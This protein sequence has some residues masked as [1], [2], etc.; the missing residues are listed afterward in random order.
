MQYIGDNEIVGKYLGSTE[1]EKQYLGDTLVWEKPAA[2]P[3]NNEIWYTSSDGQIVVPY[4]GLTPTANTYV[5]GKGVM[6]FASDLTD[7]PRG[8]FSG[9]STMTSV[10]LPQSIKTLG[11]ASFNLCIRLTAATLYEGITSEG[12][13]VFRHTNLIDFGFPSTVTS[14]TSNSYGEF[15]V[16]GDEWSGDT[17]PHTMRINAKTIGGSSALY[18]N[19]RLTSIVFSEN[20]QSFTGSYLFY[21]PNTKS[22]T[23][24]DIWFE[25]RTSLPSGSSFWNAFG[26]QSFIPSTG[27]L[28]L[29]QGVDESNLSGTLANWTK[30][31]Y[32]R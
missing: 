30:V 20:F 26:S 6:S 2:I 31:Y 1:I 12:N 28:H 32:T 10:H 18:Q 16:P 27:T 8:A 11:R 3:A 22:T 29:V 14:L 7:I 15:W 9:C 19:G 24:T 25:H 4:T 13:Y 21:P 5:N 23:L 17:L